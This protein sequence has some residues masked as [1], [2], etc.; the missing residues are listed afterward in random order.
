MADRI[1]RTLSIVLVCCAVLTT[2]VL[3]NR[4]MKVRAG[5]ATRGRSQGLTKTTQWEAVMASGATIGDTV[6]KIRVVVFSDYECPACRK[7]HA[8]LSEV[9]SERR[10]GVSFLSVHFPLDNHR[11]AR[12]AARAAECAGV[13]GRFDEMSG[14]LFAHQDSLGLKSWEAFAASAG[15]PDAARFASCVRSVTAV[16]RIEA[17]VSLGKSLRVNATPTVFVEGWRF[18]SPPTREEL[19]DVITELLAGQQPKRSSVP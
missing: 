7:A 16:D 6:A 3:A 8:V 11:F 4:E 19:A 18:S 13:Q 12:P 15:V 5:P 14:T 17:G 2:G 9:K 10:K 1:D